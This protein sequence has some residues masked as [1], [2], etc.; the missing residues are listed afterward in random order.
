MTRSPSPWT[1]GAGAWYTDDFGANW[2]QVFNYDGAECIDVS[3]FDNNLIVLTVEY[4]T[5]NPGVF[6]S[7]DRGLTWSKSNTN[8]AS[9]N[10]IED[11]FFLQ[12]GFKY[13]N[14]EVFTFFCIWM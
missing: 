5:K 8:I 3:P 13:W 10:H 6:V 14:M 9:P 2:T 12:E 7:R 11:G 1:G 4:L